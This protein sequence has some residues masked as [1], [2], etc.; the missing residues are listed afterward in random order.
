[1][2]PDSVFKAYDV[3]GR[4]DNGEL[5]PDL[6]RKIGEAFVTLVDSDEVVV[7]RDCRESSEA[8]FEALVHGITAAGADVVDLG[9]VPTDL[10][11]FY[12]GKY[13]MPGAMITA[14]HN[15][16][17]YNGLKL[18]RAGAAPVGAETGLEDIKKAGSKAMPTSPRCPARCGRSTLSTIMWITSSR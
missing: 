8:L 9:L 6:Y 4:T 13:S 5:T 14:S 7:G 15:P 11:Y 12:S 18:C 10:V 17:E 16:P 3:R 2:S 1:M